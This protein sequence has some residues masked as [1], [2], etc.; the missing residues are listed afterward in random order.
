MKNITSRERTLKALSYKE[1]DKVPLFLA[2][3]FYGAKELGITIKEYFSKSEN[4]VYAQRK[5][6][7]K[8]NHDFYYVFFY[9]SLE[10][11][12]FGGESIFIDNGPPNAGEPIIKKLSDIDNLK[13]PDVRNS[14]VLKK[15]FET[16]NALKNTDIPVIGVIISPFSLPIMQMG[17]DKYIEL[18]YFQ[19]D[20]FWKLM[21]K[22]MDFSSNFA[23]TQL[24]AGADII[25]YF[26]P[27]LST[28]MMPKKVLKETG[29]LVAKEMFKKI[30]GPIA[31]HMASARVSDSVEDIIDPKV[32]V[33]SFG[34]DDDIEK[35]KETFK[36]KIA[37]VGNLD[38]ISM[39]HWTVKEAK[40]KVKKLILKGAKG[41]GFIIGDTHGEIPWYVSEE[42]LLS[43]SESVQKYGTYPIRG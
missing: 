6:R 9:A 28:E 14:F 40:E 7:E 31:I 13:I 32:R 27:L 30:A 33:V 10:I 21:R 25:V 16:E 2:F 36:G 12:A 22:N 43:I 38:G 15:V 1:P 29:F 23:N 11:E 18:I 35:L 17:F 41:G 39:K 3:T 5:L 26:D 8:Y 19:R 4:V 37:F 20:Y 34:T 42:V 24:K